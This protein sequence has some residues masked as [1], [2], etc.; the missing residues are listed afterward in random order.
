VTFRIHRA[1]GRQTIV[2]ALSGELNTEHA[3]R[4]LADVLSGETDDR[5]VL[6]LKDVTLVDRAAVQLL[7][8]LEGRGIRIVNFPDY[9]R[10][11]IEA[12]RRLTQ[13]EDKEP[14]A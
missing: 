5:I 7:A 2:F 9:V 12:E 10:S 3:D 11:W 4:V 13:A 1:T 8:R 6:D 14:T